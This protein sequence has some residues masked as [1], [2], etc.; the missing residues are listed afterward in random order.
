MLPCLHAALPTIRRGFDQPPNSL[1]KNY[2]PVV[3]AAL[4][5]AHRNLLIPMQH[6][7]RYGYAHTGMD[8][9]NSGFGEH[10]VHVIFADT[11]ARHHCYSLPSRSHQFHN[12]GDTIFN[13]LLATRGQNTINP[14]RN[15][16]FQCA[17][18]VARHI[19]C[20]VKSGLQRPRNPD[21]M[22]RPG[23]I[24]PPIFLQDSKNNSI[25]TQLLCGE[26][27]L[28]HGLEFIAAVAKVASAGADHHPY[29]YRDLATD[30][31]DQ[32]GAGSHAAF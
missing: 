6:R 20:T 12:R 25:R 10:T 13:F 18:E 31:R 24:Y 29:S 17:A 9:S 14:G 4:D 23:H 32:P 30:G 19:K 16:V 21:Q 26:N 2:S 7:A 8:F 22:A 27:V 11:A 28:L 5:R 3:L 15:N 1:L